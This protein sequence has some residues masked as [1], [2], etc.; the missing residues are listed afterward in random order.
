M[1]RNYRNLFMV[2]VMAFA[3]CFTGCKEEEAPA[4]S[5]TVDGSEEFAEEIQSTSASFTL[6][7]NGIS[8]VAYLVEEGNVSET[9]KDAAVVYA[10]A[11]EAGRVVA[12]VDGANTTV[13]VYSLELN[14]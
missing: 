6:K 4:L 3:A 12:V 13:N 8:S 5:V 11:E 1:K 14:V 9:T 7:T 2:G 10:E